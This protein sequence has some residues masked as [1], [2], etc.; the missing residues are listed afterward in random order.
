VTSTEPTPAEAIPKRR[1]SRRHNWARIKA[2]YTEGITD[3]R[4]QTR[5]PSLREVAELNNVHSGKVR[6]R[7][8]A[9]RWTTEREQF[10]AR[11][12]SIRRNERATELAAL[13]ADLDVNALRVARNGLAVTAARIQ[14][15]G[16][17][18]QTRAEALRQ[19]GGRIGAGLPPAPDSEE[20]G[21]LS[22]AA[23]QWYD[24]GT[25]ALGDIPTQ[26]V[27]LDLGVTLEQA[28]VSMSDDERAVRLVQILTEAG[29]LPD[30]GPGDVLDVDGGPARS[31]EAGTRP[32]DE[33]LHPED[34]HDDGEP[35]P[36]AAGVPTA[37][38]A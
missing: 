31:L 1:R 21:V 30:A 7:A 22:R 18:A 13:G 24:L 9:E 36:Q 33:P 27:E 3:D 37:Q 4:G 19:S 17:Q 23:G 34:A 25:K 14:E 20:L 29:V 2:Q 28:E 5:W 35:E 26:R 11:I 38:S 10:Q 8:A 15:L 16:Q 12:E 6:D 32:E